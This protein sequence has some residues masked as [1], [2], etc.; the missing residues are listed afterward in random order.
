MTAISAG[1]PC[2]ARRGVGLHSGREPAVVDEVLPKGYRVKF[3]DG[4]VMKVPRVWPLKQE[5][6]ASLRRKQQRQADWLVQG[7]KR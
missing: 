3:A 1:S 7:A 4:L 5:R 6:K 2:M